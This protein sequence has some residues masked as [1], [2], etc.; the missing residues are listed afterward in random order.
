MTLTSLTPINTNISEFS[1]G[2]VSFL[3]SL[4]LPSEGILV[5][6]DER[7]RVIQMFPHVVTLINP[8]VR[9]VSPYLSKFIAACGAGLFDAALNFLWDETVLHLRNKVVNFDLNYFYD[10]VETDP[11]K[12]SKLKT[13]ADLVE[14]S[15]WELIKGC[16]DIGILSDI[17]YKHLD[18]IRDM[19]NW[20]SAAHPNQNQLSGLMLVSWLETCIKEVIAK[21]PNNSAV[22]VKLLLNNIRTQVLSYTDA[23]H[24]QHQL[25]L[26]PLDTIKTLLRSLFGMYSDTKLT[27]QIRENI[28]LIIKKVWDIS[29]DQ[30]KYECGFRYNRFLSNAEVDKKNLAH[31]FL[32]L[33]NGLPF[34]PESV[35]AVEIKEKVELLYQTHT[36]FNNFYNE[37]TPAR[38]LAEYVPNT[39]I[40]PNSIRKQYIKTVVMA[41]IGNGYGTS[42]MAMPYYDL[43]ISKFGEPE[44]REV[45][46]LLLDEEFS[47]R[48]QSTLAGQNFHNL[49]ARILPLTTN[50]VTQGILNLMV[51]AGLAQLK[52]LGKDARYKQATQI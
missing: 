29:P 23:Q 27:S 24:I 15:E 45:S 32:T 19:R 42:S 34:L 37:P 2:F 8:Q 17:G 43:M 22:Q 31:D 41:K 20:A 46:L 7:Y 49:L 36:S 30:E 40:I 3:Q 14:V 44:Y 47:S 11:T 48:L 51:S 33:V 21:E 28:K 12:R 52:I 4:E 18:Y 26:L 50:T 5:D 25:E 1:Q 16:K 13:E 9:A 6:L 39:G 35:L 10:T 38:I